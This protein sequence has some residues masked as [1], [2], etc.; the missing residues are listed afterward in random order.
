METNFYVIQTLN[1]VTYLQTSH[2]ILLKT[3]PSYKQIKLGNLIFRRQV[4]TNSKVNNF[5]FSKLH[6][7]RNLYQSL[8]DFEF[9]YIYEFIGVHNCTSIYLLICT[10]HLCVCVVIIKSVRL[11]CD[12]QL[13]TTTPSN[14]YKL[15]A[16]SR[17][18]VFSYTTISRHIKIK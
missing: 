1:S 15:I 9:I 17:K 6:G 8:E 11:A 5:L 2:F 3:T 4:Q 13:V 10:P 7:K 12:K 18:G 14:Y 16:S